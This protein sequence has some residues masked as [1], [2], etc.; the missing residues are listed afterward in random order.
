IGGTARK[1][2]KRPRRQWR[3]LLRYSSERRTWHETRVAPPT[4]SCARARAILHN[5]VHETRCC[6]DPG[7]ARLATL[8]LHPPIFRGN[9]LSTALRSNKRPEPGHLRFSRRYLA[10]ASRS[11]E[12]RFVLRLPL[13]SLPLFSNLMRINNRKMVLVKH[14]KTGHSPE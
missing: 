5:A 1:K 7:L 12:V 14:L 6:V 9:E 4:E 13:D 8:A 11:A 2:S 3:K 10:S